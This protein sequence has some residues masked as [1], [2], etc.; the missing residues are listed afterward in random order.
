MS[1]RTILT[2]LRRPASFLRSRKDVTKVLLSTSANDRPGNLLI[3]LD[4]FGTI[5]SPRIP[6][7]FQYAGLGRKYG[8]E[9]SVHDIEQ[10]FK[11]AYRLLK[12]KHP[13]YGRETGISPEEWWKN[14]VIETF[15]PSW[16]SPIPR[17][18][19]DALWH[20]FASKSGYSLCASAL[21][22]LAILSDLRTIADKTRAGE[23]DWMF[24]TITLGVITNSDDRVINVLQ[25]LD[26]TVN[27]QTSVSSSGEVKLLPV[28]AG[29]PEDR[30]HLEKKVDL[31][32]TSYQVG[33]E[34][35][36]KGIFD[37]A[38]TSAKQVVNLYYGEGEAERGGWY[39]CHIGDEVR[40][41]IVG[42]MRAGG[43]GV[44]YDAKRKEGELEREISIDGVGPDGRV[45]VINDLREMLEM[46]DVL[47]FMEPYTGLGWLR[48]PN[49]T[50]PGQ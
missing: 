6:V 41:D 42:T 40:G 38:I 45:M 12:E 44:L 32:T 37:A 31:V 23:Q 1:I 20:N 18:L 4:A 47:E 29:N 22:F 3:T 14:V 24:K 43:V 2:S 19:R 48:D 33:V 5:Y 15:K 16:K 10:N 35:P 17:V 9:V 36:N 8:V 46:L 7:P 11:H 13:N 28:G 34:K 25:D 49:S 21:P 39:W 30:K 50:T 27:F 26:I